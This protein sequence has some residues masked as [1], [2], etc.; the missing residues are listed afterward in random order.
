[1]KTLFD[2][3][4]FAKRYVD[5]KGSQEVDDVCQAT[6]VLALSVVCVPEIISALNR[7]VR[8]KRLSAQEYLAA[9]SRLSEDVADAL[10]VNLTPAVIARATFLLETT[11]LRAP[12]MRCMSLVR[13]NGGQN[14]SFRATIARSRLPSGLACRRDASRLGN[15]SH[16]SGTR[17]RLPVSR[18]RS[19]AAGWAVRRLLVDSTGPRPMSGHNPNDRPKE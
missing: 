10:I 2:S 19:R 17:R 11:A 7:W 16:F 5:E 4:A 12:W 14:F 8:E 15:T 1:M 18:R 13:W 9:K 3:S 6:S